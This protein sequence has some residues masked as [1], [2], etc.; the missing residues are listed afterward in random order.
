MKSS[1]SR[2]FITGVICVL[3]CMGSKTAAAQSAAPCSLLT[4]AQVSAAVGVTA[5]AGTPIANTGCSWTVTSPHIIV[6][7]SLWD[8]GK[9][10][11]MKAPL[12]G[13]TKTPVSGLGDDAVF[14]AMGPDAKFTTLSVK[15]GGTVY[16]FKV[17]GVDA[18]KQRSTEQALA[19]NALANVH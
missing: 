10:D 1:H 6:T 5:G 8:G 19:A 4:S 11:Q 18:P 3:A 7:L 2:H 12:P 16:T 13:M 9:W 15:K 17:Y 14:T